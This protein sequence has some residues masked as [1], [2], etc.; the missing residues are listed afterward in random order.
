MR[1]LIA[2]S[3]VL[4]LLSCS[5][6]DNE[7]KIRYDF[8]LLTDESVYF[9]N[10]HAAFTAV[11]SYKGNLYLA[12]REGLNH[13]P[14][15]P[16]EYGVIKILKKVGSGW[17]FVSEI[18]SNDKDLRDPYFLVVNGEL[19]LYCGYNQNG[20]K[21]WEHIATVYSELRGGQWSEL[22]TISHDVNHNVW[23]WKAREYKGKYYGVAFLEKETPVLMESDDA[24][25]WHSLTALEI[26]GSGVYTEAD[27]CF[28][29]DSLY[30]CI[31][32][33]VPKGA[34]ATWG[35][36][37][38]PFKEFD[39][40]TMDAGI[41]SPELFLTKTGQILLAGR[42]YQLADGKITHNCLTIFEI[43]P[44][45]GEIIQKHVLWQNPIDE[46]LGYTEVGYPSMAYDGNHL[47]LSYYQGY[48]TT[49]VRVSEISLYSY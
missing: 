26:G 17:E 15:T 47:F 40:K 31:R 8:T 13:V 44:L 41:D 37:A 18:A 5:N 30:I 7:S 9:Q 38:Y 43:A 34:S 32:N 21:G 11:V 29:G 12:F 36:S 49:E 33:D 45:L 2:I 4:G 20:P 19:R 42:E 25:I 24:S 23:I 22:R 35:K 6:D 1:L 16:E 28:K 27:C 39:W 46:L 14:T 48:K 10:D 3:L